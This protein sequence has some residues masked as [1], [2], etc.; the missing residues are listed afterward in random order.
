MSQTRKCPR[1]YIRRRG[2]TRKNTGTYVKSACIRSTSGHLSNPYKTM[3]R[4]LGTRKSCPP[5]Q[6]SRKAYV[7]RISSQVAR[8]GYL[9]RTRSGKTIRVRPHVKSTFVPA[10]C[11]KDTGKKGKLAVGVKGIGPLRKGELSKHGYSYK[12]PEATRKDALRKAIGEFGPLSTYRKLNAVSKLTERTNPKAS[13][14]FKEDRNWIQRSY[15][16]AGVVRAF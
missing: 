9:K 13:K 4:H 15:A 12:A 14:I 10:S 8:Q 11:V 1:G 2:Y 5:G 3:R 16:E 7:R 6:I